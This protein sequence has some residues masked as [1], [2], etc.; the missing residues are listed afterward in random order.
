MDAIRKNGL[1]VLGIIFVLLGSGQMGRGGEGGF[2]IAVTGAALI[3]FGAVLRAKAGRD[4]GDN[5]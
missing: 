3:I 4:G 2:L 5:V 1:L